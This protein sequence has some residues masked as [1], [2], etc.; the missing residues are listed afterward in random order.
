MFRALIAFALISL[1]ASALAQGTGPS[2]LNG[3]YAIMDKSGYET[4]AD[5]KR[6]NVV[7][8]L[9]SGN[10][11]ITCEKVRFNADEIEWFDDQNLVQ[12][13]G[14]V[15]M[16]Q[17]ELHLYAERA[18]VDRNTH[19]GTFF[20]AHGTSQTTQK[21]PAKDLFGGPEPDVAF[22]AEEMAK[23]GPETFEIKNGTVTSCVQATPRWSLSG[24]SGTFVKDKR[25]TFWNAVL[26]VKDVPVFYAP[27]IFYPIN[28]EGR[29][30][31]FL[32]PSFG[33]STVSG[34]TLSNAFFWAID[35]SRDATFYHDYRKKAGNGFGTQYRF[36]SSPVSSGEATVYM[37]DQ[38]AR[39]A[40]GAIA[41]QPAQRSYTLNG[42]F[43]EGLAHGFRFSGTA[44]YFTSITAQQ[45]YQQNVY[46]STQGTRSLAATLTGGRRRYRFDATFAQNDAYSSSATPPSRHGYAPRVSLSMAEAPIGRS[47]IYFGATGE[48]AYLVSQDNIDLPSTNHSLLRFDASPTVR[49][50]MSSLSFLTVTTSASWRITEWM[51][52]LD[53]VTSTQSATPLTRQLFS[54]QTRMVGPVFARVWQPKTNKY[55]ERVKHLIEPSFSVQWYSPFDKLTQVVRADG[56]DAIVGGTTTINYG[57]ANRVLIRPRRASATSPAGPVREIVSLEITQSHYTN[58]LAAAVDSQYLPCSTGAFSAVQVAMTARPIDKLSG[59]FRTDV[60][61]QFH[62]PCTLSASGGLTLKPIQISLGWTKKQYIPGLP[63]FNDPALADQFLNAAATFRQADGHLG[64]TYSLNYDLHHGFA[65]QQHL[66][67][68]YNSQCCGL[69]VEYQTRD[70]GGLAGLR[71]LHSFNF[72]FTLAGLG[73]FS[74]PLGSFGK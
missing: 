31:G 36:V 7:R 5:P 68:F 8:W 22:W 14:H 71:S 45:L 2:P 49:W 51:E 26:R 23:T 30:S 58:A 41:A 27:F 65:L 72:S 10:V 67:V 53:P 69:S 55:A 21:K 37:L 15:V 3:C 64:G 35:R 57:L 1:P 25:V 63:N 42:Q 44:N 62:T 18:I 50:P 19:L 61:P 34:F 66:M 43:I 56:T 38:R 60:N 70:L 17:L 32:M 73:S 33:S 16:E 46:A 40:V 9:I 12:I 28:K 29:S 4:I 20:N 74:N 59:Q 13:R 39:P 6:P 48:T 47:R 54:L 11:V 52:S 24:T